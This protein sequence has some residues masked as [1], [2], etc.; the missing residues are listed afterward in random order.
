MKTKQLP[1]EM[2]IK[3]KVVVITG[4]SRGLGRV[5]A[6]AF[7]KEGARLVLSSRSVDELEKMRRLSNAKANFYF[8]REYGGKEVDLIIENYKKEYLAI[9]IKVEKGGVK[10]I[11]PL[12]NTAEIISAQNYFEKITTIFPWIVMGYYAGRGKRTGF[13]LG[14]FLVGIPNEKGQI[15]SIAKIG[16]GLSDEQWKELKVQG[17]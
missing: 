4:A 15:G 17:R 13:G 7:A 14:A 2:I 11:F 12:P 16:T 5:L 1:W 6:L 10:D 9:E 8:Y 3:D